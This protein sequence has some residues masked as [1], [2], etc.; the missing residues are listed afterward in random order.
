MTQPADLLQQLF[1][2]GALSQQNFD[3][4]SRYYGLPLMAAAT[5]SGQTVRYVSRRFVPDPRRLTVVQTYRVQQ[6]DRIDIVAATVMGKALAYWQICDANLAV[7]PDDICAEPG[8]VIAIA[9]PLS[10]TGG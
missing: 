8:R 1:A 6:H 5:P 2:A 9:L 3:V 10:G 7:D 4:D